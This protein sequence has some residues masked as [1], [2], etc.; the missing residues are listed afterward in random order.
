[1]EMSAR[2]NIKQLRSHETNAPTKHARRGSASSTNAGLSHNRAG[3]DGRRS[4][5]QTQPPCP[6]TWS[7][8]WASTIA[9]SSATVSNAVPRC[10]IRWQLEHTSA[11][12][13]ILVMASPRRIATGTVHPVAARHHRDRIARPVALRDDAPLLC[14]APPPPRRIHLARSRTQ[15][16]RR[17]RH[18]RSCPLDSWTPPRRSFAIAHVRSIPPVREGGPHR[19]VTLPRAYSCA[20]VSQRRYSDLASSIT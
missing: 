10:S 1:M 9:R 20:P 7:D 13:D 14:L 11:M 8:E 6:Q 4:L 18:L 15:L 16:P 2:R 17:I 12:S 3:A 5:R 19:M